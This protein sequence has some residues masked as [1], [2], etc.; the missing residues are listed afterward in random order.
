MQSLKHSYTRNGICRNQRAFTLVEIIGVLAI[1]SIIVGLLLPP[2]F[3]FVDNANVSA[4]THTVRA[5]KAAIWEYY[6]QNKS[7]PPTDVT[8]VGAGLLDRP[9]DPKV[10]A[11]AVGDGYLRN[12]T[13]TDENI[14]VGG[15]GITGTNFD[16]SGD[17]MTTQEAPAGA[18]LV[19]LELD[20]VNRDNAEA[21]NEAIDGATLGDASD[22]VA[23]DG[24][25]ELGAVIYD[26]RAGFP[27]TVYIY[28]AHQ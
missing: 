13:A 1:I 3:R 16:L 4:V 28:L 10:G 27:T 14:A 23:G 22:S 20:D 12:L 8:L 24:A 18:G 15:D 7:F 26:G 21:L 19:V 2:I 25:D 6:V 5:S 11:D 9:I 17:G